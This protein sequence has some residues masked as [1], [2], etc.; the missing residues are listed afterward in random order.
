MT[1]R[2]RTTVIPSTPT[3]APSFKVEKTQLVKASTGFWLITHGDHVEKT[4]PPDF[5]LPKRELAEL[6]ITPE[7]EALERFVNEWGIFADPE[8]RDIPFSEQELVIGAV[9]EEYLSEKYKNDQSF[10]NAKLDTLV[11]LGLI[12][13]AQTSATGL[14]KRLEQG[15]KL[16]DL[17]KA[18]FR[19]I[20]PV[21]LTFRLFL[22]ETFIELYSIL[23]EE[24]PQRPNDFSDTYSHFNTALSVFAVRLVIE[25]FV[26]N[27]QRP[28]MFNAVALQIANDILLD[29]PRHICAN[30]NC[31]LEFTR[32]RGRAQYGEYRMKEVLYCSSSC[33]RAQAARNL[34]RR[35]AAERNLLATAGSKSDP[36][37]RKQPEV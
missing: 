8:N 14:V 16:F 1:L 10:T 18:G 19:I 25:D 23:D 3:E 34:R 9:D 13:P 11:E 17:E 20:N 7:L 5:Y 35:R 24:T 21:E 2:L 37:L 36:E 33:A 31:G 15:K 26:A 12:T 4:L 32:Q 28:T 6:T 30:D 22:L 27:D 29:V